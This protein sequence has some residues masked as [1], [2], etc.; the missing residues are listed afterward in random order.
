LSGDICNDFV[1]VDGGGSAVGDKNEKKRGCEG[2]R[3][4]HLRVVFKTMFSPG[5]LY[6][7]HEN[8]VCVANAHLSDDETVAKMGHPA[9]G[10]AWEVK[11]KRQ[12]W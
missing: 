3:E 9:F 4:F 10:I 12:W 7:K 1:G 5:T 2:R 11:S 6:A 8:A